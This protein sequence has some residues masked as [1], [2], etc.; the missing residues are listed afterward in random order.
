M[1]REYPEEIVIDVATLKEG[2]RVIVRRMH[3]IDNPYILTA[4]ATVSPQQ[5]VV[6][7]VDGQHFSRD[8]WGYE[9]DKKYS[10]RLLQPTNDILYF[11]QRNALLQ[12][13]HSIDWSNAPIKVL[14]AV[15]TAYKSSYGL[16]E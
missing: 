13:I 15:V 1:I 6:T 16:I 7:T 9:E 4:V 3:V 14:E 8:G 12:Y 10:Y 5:K 2:D 11:I